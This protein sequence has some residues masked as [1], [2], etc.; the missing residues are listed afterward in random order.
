MDYKESDMYK[1]DEE[2]KEEASERKYGIALKIRFIIRLI[3]VLG[4]AAY[5]VYLLFFNK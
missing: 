5:A 1:T 2:L 4:A 3:F